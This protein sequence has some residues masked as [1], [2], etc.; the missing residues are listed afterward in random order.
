MDNTEFLLSKF[1][2]IF[3]QPLSPLSQYLKVDDSDYENGDIQTKTE[4]DEV[5]LET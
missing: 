2:H 3:S 4:S 5:K 1:S